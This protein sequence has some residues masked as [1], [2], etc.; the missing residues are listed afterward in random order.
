MIIARDAFNNIICDV[1]AF[2]I[3]SEGNAINV[4][5]TESYR[6]VT[7]NI[8]SHKVFYAIDWIFEQMQAQRGNA[9]IFIDVCKCPVCEEEKK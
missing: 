6:Q 4:E 9:N 5:N 2:Y 1:K 3:N 7:K 8:G